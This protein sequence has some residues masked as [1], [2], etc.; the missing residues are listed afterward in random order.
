MQE[1]TLFDLELPT[2][3]KDK[4]EMFKERKISGGGVLHFRRNYENHGT[5]FR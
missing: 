1:L 4:I 3:A 2:S 5:F